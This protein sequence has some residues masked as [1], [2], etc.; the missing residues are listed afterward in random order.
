MAVHDGTDLTPP[1]KHAAHQVKNFKHELLDKTGKKL[2]K[3]RTSSDLQRLLRRLTPAPGLHRALAKRLRPTRRAAKTNR[4]A[5]PAIRD[6]AIQPV[7]KRL[8][9]LAAFARHTFSDPNSDTCFIR[10]I[11][12]TSRCTSLLTLLKTYEKTNCQ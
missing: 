7:L 9:T 3:K 10:S 8:Q 2:L 5:L 6:T 4:R 1:Q 11:A 12:S